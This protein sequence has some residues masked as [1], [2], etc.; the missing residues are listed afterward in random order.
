MTLLTFFAGGSGGGIT[1][2][3]IPFWDDAPAESVEPTDTST[4][5]VDPV[6]NGTGDVEPR[7]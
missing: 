1:Y 7:E 4:G 5:N 2:P 3:S 6:D